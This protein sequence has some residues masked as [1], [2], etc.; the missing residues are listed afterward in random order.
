MQELLKKIEA[1]A[2]ARLTLPPGRQPAQELARYKG[3]LKVET[4]RLK[5]LHRAGAGG[6]QICR[7]RAAILD[8]LI[9]CLWETAKSSLS[10]QG[11]KD[12]PQ[13]AIVAIGGYGRAELNPHSDI[14]FMFLHNRQMAGARPLPHLSRI[15]DGILYPLWD[16]GLKVGHSVRSIEDCVKVANSDMQSKTSL[17]ESRLIAGDQAL[18][19]KFQKTLVSKCV[20]KH[21][22]EYIAMRL[23]DQ[24]T[25]RAKSGNSACM[26]EPNLKNGCGGLRDF[27][28][29][30]W[31]A[32]FKHRTRSLKD[33]QGHDLITESERKQL[34]AAYDFLLRVRTEMHYHANRPTDVLSKALQPAIAHNL[35]YR[36]RSPSKR[37]EQ[38]MRELYLHSRNI[39]I[40]TRTLEQRLALW[41]EP[42]K[43]AG[44]AGFTLPRGLT[45]LL[46]RGSKPAPEPVDGFTFNAAEIVAV[47]NRVFREHPRRLMRVF[48]YAQQ[49]GLRLHPDLAQLVRN[50]LSLVDRAFLSDAHVRDTFLAI[51]NQRG[52]VAPILRAMHE[53]GLLGKYIPEFGKLTCLV[54]HEFYHQYSADEHTLMCLEQL[55]RI[56]DAKTPLYN[57]YLPLF[58]KLERPFVLYLALLLHDVGKP[59]GHGNHS[60]VSSELALRVARRLGLD[61]VTTHTLRQ[62]IEHH[63]LMASLSQRR[64]L[65]DPAVVRQFVKRVEN[66]ENLALLTLLTFADAQ[67]TS[68]KLWN[69][70]KDSLLWSLHRKAMEEM[71][72]GVE[73]VRVEEK[74]REALLAEVTALLPDALSEE[75]VQ[76]HFGTLP[77]RY[78][79]VQP[80]RE[81]LEDLDLAHR[82]MRLQISETES[83]LTPVIE[84]HDDPDRAC[85]AVKVCTWD[86]AGLFRKIAG[87][88]SAAGLNI[89]S[90]Q[91]FSRVDGI[92]LDTFF[93]NDAKTGNLAGAEQRDKFQH[94]L[95]RSL[96]DEE[97]D[98]PALIARQKLT[99]PVY[100]AYTGEQLPTRIA[101]DNESSD[102]RTVIEVETEDRIGLLYTISQTLTDLELDISGAKICTEK[103]AAIDSFY[104]RE[105]DGG[106][107][108]D[109]ERAQAIERKLRS[110]VAALDGG[111]N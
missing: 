38:F 22:E 90:A 24:A 102:S 20:E 47:S 32:F 69:G 35:G 65:D 2:A 79:L 59:D 107:I 49:R 10:E 46:P 30:L 72:Q 27:Q 108:V 3:F 5:I 66:P 94:L 111:L 70:F 6:L 95:N 11:Q 26:Q 106:K 34:E 29:L 87:S 104:V 84:W 63:L 54:Q 28:N 96:N 71:T 73:L 8:V 50:Q 82:F 68:D 42:P 92:V 33:L 15:I 1:N 78:F 23:E 67:A 39:F 13:L 86:R 57:T 55:D 53:V 103:G 4:H 98:F 74:Q 76:A 89:F 48:L 41:P 60:Q 77:P 93:V 99:R 7:A 58:Q 16:V 109:P 61:A 83:P 21:E 43:R 85:N 40:I 97:L 45:K 18:F 51:L 62:V 91:I 19:A 52:N 14:D 101:L 56:W 12:F 25:R 88:L 105:L 110:V 36:E 64:D 75:E 31:M 37:I 9:R 17:I 100:Q 81:V 44:L 80:A